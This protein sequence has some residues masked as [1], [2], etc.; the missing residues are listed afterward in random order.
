MNGSDYGRAR[1]AS[2]V[3]LIAGV[4]GGGLAW[5][6]VQKSDGYFTPAAE[7]VRNTGQAIS[8]EA[9]KLIDAE[10]RRTECKNAALSAGLF[11]IVVGASLGVG[12][13]ISQRS[14]RVAGLALLTGALL[15]GA[16]AAIGGY[17]EVLVSCVSE[18]RRQGTDL[19]GRSVASDSGRTRA[20][21]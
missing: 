3:L 8:P 4:L 14:V 12:R 16:L 6:L 18:P 10:K 20:P 5:M 15:G 2:V 9:A 17:V 1:G 19:P 7:V 13:G 11:G 21:C